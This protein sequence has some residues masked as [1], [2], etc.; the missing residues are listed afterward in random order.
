LLTQSLYFEVR[1]L[2]PLGVLLV[3]LALYSELVIYFTLRVCYFVS[4]VGVNLKFP[5]SV[6]NFSYQFMLIILF[7][8][9][10]MNCFL[11]WWYSCS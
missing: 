11:K 7:P 1:L 6:M 5:S 3:S 2:I 9:L 8:L 4:Y 10:L